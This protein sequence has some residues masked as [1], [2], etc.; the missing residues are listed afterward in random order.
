MGST[1]SQGVDI[2]AWVSSSG[3]SH[4]WKQIS[5]IHKRCHS[6]VHSFA[7]AC[8][9]GQLYYHVVPWSSSC[10][11]EMPTKSLSRWASAWATPAL[12]SMNEGLALRVLR[13]PKSHF[14]S[15]SSSRPPANP[16]P[17]LFFWVE[18]WISNESGGRQQSSE[19]LRISK[20][21]DHS[22]D[23]IIP[24]TLSPS[25]KSIYSEVRFYPVQDL[26]LP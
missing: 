20:F 9:L 24:R 12:F 26:A 23:C 3:A 19:K 4:K 22:L 2:R 21:W 7:S 6:I 1:L 10:C 25:L 18:K 17:F 14:S 16:F 11:K 5:L 15:P 13:P 8:R